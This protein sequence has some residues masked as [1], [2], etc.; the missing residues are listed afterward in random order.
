MDELY[1]YESQP[2]LQPEPHSIAG[3]TVLL[4]KIGKITPIITNKE[5]KASFCANLFKADLHATQNKKFIKSEDLLALVKAK[6][7]TKTINLL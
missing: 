1:R 3:V 2:L 6:I 5:K 4:Q 7:R